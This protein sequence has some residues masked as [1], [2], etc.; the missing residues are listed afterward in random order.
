MVTEKL[1][2]SPPHDKVVDDRKH[3]EDERELERGHDVAHSWGHGL[4][5]AP[6]GQRL[7]DALLLEQGRTDVAIDPGVR[8]DVAAVSL[9][10]GPRS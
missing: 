3:E 1:T 6:L 9:L 5:R 10:A 7:V 2:S 8:G 4:A